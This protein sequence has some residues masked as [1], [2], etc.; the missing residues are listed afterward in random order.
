MRT[1]TQQEKD[2]VLF[3]LIDDLRASWHRRCDDLTIRGLGITSLAPLASLT[4]AGAVTL[5]EMSLERLDGLHN[6][7]TVSTFDVRSSFVLVDISALSGLTSAD[8]IVVQET[9]L[10]QLDGMPSL[11]HLHHLDVSRNALLTDI[12]GLDAIG[13]VDHAF[14]ADNPSLCRSEAE[15]WAAD[16]TLLL[17]QGAGNADC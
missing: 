16:R 13:R 3:A 4:A 17:D 6:L 9:G 7:R 11:A 1:S 8:T 5:R 15:A 12:G 2:V 14:I 10:T